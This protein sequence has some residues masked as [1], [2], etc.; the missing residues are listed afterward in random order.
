MANGQETTIDQ[1]FAENG[2]NFFLDWCQQQ[3]AFLPIDTKVFKVSVIEVR[4]ILSRYS[5]LGSKTVVFMN[6]PLYVIMNAPFEVN[7]YVPHPP[8]C[9]QDRN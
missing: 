1:I 4:K 9:P 6:A 8:Y 2:T 5:F 7:Y 3:G